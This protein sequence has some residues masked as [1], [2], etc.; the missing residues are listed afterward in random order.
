MAYQ[1]HPE[2]MQETRT[3]PAFGYCDSYFVES[4]E[5]DDGLF[6]RAAAERERAR[7]VAKQ[8]QKALGEELSRATQDEYLEDVLDHME[9]MEVSGLG[10]TCR[11]VRCGKCMPHDDAI[12][13]RSP[14]VSISYAD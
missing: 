1:Q 14:I 7:N 9:H 13:A 11:F 4:H 2:Q 12:N 6:A 8:R 5:D 3:F 10:R